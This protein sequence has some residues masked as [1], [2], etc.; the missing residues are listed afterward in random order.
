MKHVIAVLLFLPTTLLFILARLLW[1]LFMFFHNLHYLNID[2]IVL[3][4]YQQT[5]SRFVNTITKLVIMTSELAADFIFSIKEIK[6]YK[7]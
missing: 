3:E 5:T 7:F 4:E 1:T 2:K 6:R